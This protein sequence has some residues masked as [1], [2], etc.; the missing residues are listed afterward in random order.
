MARLPEY[1]RR[2]GPERGG[3]ARLGFPDGGGGSTVVGWAG[4]FRAVDDV[5]GRIA[6]RRLAEDEARRVADMAELGAGSVELGPDG[7][8]QAPQLR[9]NDSA[10]N[11]AWNVAAL[12]AYQDQAEQ[13]WASRFMERR[14]QHP[15]DPEGFRA[16]AGESVRGAL[17]AMDPRTARAVGPRLMALT[18]G[19]YRGMLGEQ[20]QRVSSNAR[21]SWTRQLQ[22]IGDELG[23]L[24]LTG[25][26]GAP[27]FTEAGGRLAAHLAAGRAGGHIDE[28]MERLLRDEYAQ[29]AVAYGVAGRAEAVARERGLE[30]AKRW[31]NDTLASPEM[32]AAG[33]PTV[34]AA[35]AEANRRLEVLRAERAEAQGAVRDRIDTIVGNVRAGVTVPVSALE[36]AARAAEAAGLS[37]LAQRAR[38]VA[39]V[40]GELAALAHSPYGALL[41]ALATAQERPAD[42]PA[43][44][45]LVT[46]LSRM[47]QDRA[48]ILA[49]DP[50]A[51]A[52]AHPT[53]R[54]VMRRQAAG[55][56]TMSDV[57]RAQDA[58]LD[59]N[60]VF[61]F[62]RRVL[63][64][65]EAEAIKQRVATMTPRQAA[66]ALQATFL[67]YGPELRPR[68]WNDLRAAGLPE[69]LRPVAL[70]LTS[71][72][73]TAMLTRYVEAV[74][75]RGANAAAIGETAVRDVR[76][77]AREEL[78]GLE[79]TLGPLGGDAAVVNDARLA[80]ETLAVAYVRS[81][82][83]ARDAARRA[84][85]E[86]VDGAFDI[87]STGAA[88]V[89]APKGIDFSREAFADALGVTLRRRLAEVPVMIPDSA[90]IDPTMP[91]AERQ[92]A[93]RRHLETYGHWR[94]SPDGMGAI[95]VDQAGRPVLAADGTPFEL[96]FGDDPQNPAIFQRGMGGVVR[97]A[98]ETAG[99]A[100]DLAA[101]VAAAESNFNARAVS[102][103]GALGLMQVMPATGEE[104]ARKLGLPWDRERMLSDPDYNAQIGA[105]YLSEM[106]GRYGGNEALAVAA[107]NMGP[108]ALDQYLAGRR[109]LPSET[110]WYVQR[111]LGEEGIAALLS[112][113]S[114][115]GG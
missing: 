61:S 78:S 115:R 88:K 62:G 90:G 11:R 49:S 5:L 29:N 109:R 19:H 91:D 75:E 73:G 27:A 28:T 55:E 36:E 22:V 69:E 94:T 65:A 74:Q 79:E 24:A 35:R 108:G 50:V 25:Q 7:L 60:G 111:V 33:G 113:R 8:P 14:A 43:A 85:E 57:V 112:A 86:V 45:A 20:R 12:K 97:R 2:V 46:E 72:G 106:L 110:Y 101:R 89:R 13:G 95:L 56:A 105:A 9:P 3:R 58:V 1:V 70:M 38:A 103:K 71:P 96:R 64:G 93:Y 40:Q 84:R 21:A 83:S 53:V 81:G 10:A 39:T 48:R 98:A 107:Y 66:D 51:Y 31:L 17:S 37:S 77:R 87:I 82:A 6:D 47:A 63:S 80:V 42:D 99:V 67:R 30:A 92:I 52:R 114:E 34:N 102:G 4:A 16:W 23:A 76:D 104:V 41:D 26:Q 100:P 18:E 44:G 59:E 68:V 15:N 54:D 32:A